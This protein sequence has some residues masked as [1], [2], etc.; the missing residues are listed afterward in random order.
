[1]A[2]RIRENFAA[3]GTRLVEGES[4]KT[5]VSLGVTEFL[6]GESSEAF[7]TRADDAMYEAKRA[8]KNRSVVRRV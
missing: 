4:V 7:I 1:V 5:T 3:T 2:E 6:A 8:G